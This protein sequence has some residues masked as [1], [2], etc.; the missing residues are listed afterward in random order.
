MDLMLVAFLG[1]STD[2]RLEIVDTADPFHDHSTPMS[3]LPGPK[4][5]D[6][7]HRFSHPGSSE[8][9]AHDRQL[10]G[11]SERAAEVHRCSALSIV[12]FVLC[13]R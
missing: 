13:R 1:C 9:G 4:Y 5:S 12:S 11:R 3:P 7:F 2:Q 10:S 6:L 8:A